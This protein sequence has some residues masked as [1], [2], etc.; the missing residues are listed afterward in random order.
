MT[1]NVIAEWNMT[2]TV[3]RFPYIPRESLK[4]QVQEVLSLATRERKS[5]VILLY[6]NG[7]VGKTYFVRGLS[8]DLPR[9]KFIWLGQYDV[10]DAEFWLLSNL[11]REIAECLDPENR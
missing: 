3:A 1:L 4:S 11:E 10:D 8:D 6:G 9:E 2:I 7:G 5:Q